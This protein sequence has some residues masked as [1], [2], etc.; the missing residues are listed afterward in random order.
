MKTY[1]ISDRFKSLRY[2]GKQQKPLDLV[3][4]LVST[5]D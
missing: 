5:C 3:K 2:C 1:F 4:Q